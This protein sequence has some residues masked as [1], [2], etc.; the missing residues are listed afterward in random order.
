M[1]PMGRGFTVSR[2]SA[3]PAAG[4]ASGLVATLA[5][6]IATTA[7]AADSLSAATAQTVRV[8]IHALNGTRESLA[9]GDVVV[10]AGDTLLFTRLH[11]D[12]EER[13]TRNGPVRLACWTRTGS[14]SYAARP[15]TWVG[16]RSSE[17]SRESCWAS[18]ARRSSPRIRSGELATRIGT[19]SGHP[20]GAVPLAPCSARGLERSP[21]RSAGSRWTASSCAG[22]SREGLLRLRRAD[23]ASALA[24]PVPRV[25]AARPLGAATDSGRSRAIRSRRVAAARAC[26][27]R[28]RIIP[29]SM[30]AMHSFALEP[31]QAWSDCWGSVRAALRASALP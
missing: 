12:R 25:I 23:A 24:P 21:I 11:V 28:C 15:A 10:I 19:P 4:L 6:G 27:A 29:N 1:N 5:F 31:E 16:E 22:C 17:A 30:L 20:W 13:D 8:R 7:L 9:V 18:S 3:R 14:R 2:S 26:L